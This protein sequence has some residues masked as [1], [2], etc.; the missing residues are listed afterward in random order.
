MTRVTLRD[1][2]AGGVCVGKTRVWFDTHGLDFRDFARNGID[3]ET[4][5]AIDD[6]RD[7]VLSVVKHAEKREAEENGGRR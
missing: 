6:N 5:L 2:R 3:S 4:V 7:E 1:M